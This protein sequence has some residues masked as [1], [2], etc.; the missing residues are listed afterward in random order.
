MRSS[1]V[2]FGSQIILVN[3]LNG[4]LAHRKAVNKRSTESPPCQPVKSRHCHRLM[5]FVEEEESRNQ[6]KSLIT[7]LKK[8]PETSKS[9][10][11]PSPH[12]L[13]VPSTDWL[14]HFSSASHPYPSREDDAKFKSFFRLRFKDF[15][16][17]L[18][19]QSIFQLETRNSCMR[20]SSEMSS[21][22]RG[23]VGGKGKNPFFRGAKLHEESPPE[24]SSLQS[25]IS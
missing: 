19:S 14:T 25:K 11:I 24:W 8:M 21:A 2:T 7:Q 5:A 6:V 16:F 23:W 15:F 18:T 1:S 9:P 13:T 4:W 12:P 10:D 3:A 22:R 20:F 17:S